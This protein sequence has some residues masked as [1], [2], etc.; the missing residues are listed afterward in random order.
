MAI[1]LVN[2]LCWCLLFLDHRAFFAKSYGSCEKTKKPLQV[3]CQTKIFFSLIF[4]SCL[5]DTLRYNQ[6][7]GEKKMTTLIV[8]GNKYKVYRN[9]ENGKRKL[10]GTF[11]SSDDAIR[12]MNSVA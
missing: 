7:N 8:I 2:L 1:K 11:K 12:F 9:L 5:D 4:F 10:L 3:S 6:E